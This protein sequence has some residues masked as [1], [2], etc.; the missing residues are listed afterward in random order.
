MSRKP[1]EKL[2]MH[3]TSSIC[4]A[5][6]LSR[7]IP[8][9]HSLVDNNY[10]RRFQPLK[11]ALPAGTSK[12]VLVDYLKTELSLI[13]M[14]VG[15]GANRET[16][17]LRSKTVVTS[18]VY[19]VSALFD[20]PSIFGKKGRGRQTVYVVSSSLSEGKKNPLHNMS[21]DFPAS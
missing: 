10:N 17:M 4:P 19:S 2:A 13:M 3:R 1:F 21:L 6:Y 5:F 18:T 15:D 7:P 16:V 11:Y 9:G 14:K 12:T 20:A 8:C